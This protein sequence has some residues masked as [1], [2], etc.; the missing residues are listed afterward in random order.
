MAIINRESFLSRSMPVIRLE[1]WRFIRAFLSLVVII[2]GGLS[3]GFGVG[4]GVGRDDGEGESEGLGGSEGRKDGFGV[5]FTDGDGLGDTDG[6]TQFD[7]VGHWGF[8]HFRIALFGSLLVFKQASPGPHS[9][10][11]S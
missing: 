2:S 9:L 7:L 3:V 4:F 5:G 10:G 11:S 8:R 6:Q 1:Y